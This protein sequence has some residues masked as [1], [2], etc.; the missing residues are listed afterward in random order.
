MVVVVVWRWC[1]GGP[2]VFSVFAVK[3]KDKKKEDKN[4]EKR[5]EEKEREQKQNR[6][7]ER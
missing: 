7:A 2:C 5:E 1:G 3:G 4:T 6:L